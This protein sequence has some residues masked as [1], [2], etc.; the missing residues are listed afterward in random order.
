MKVTQE[1]VVD[2]QTTLRIELEEADLNPYL[3]Q[4][5]RRLAPQISLPGFRK[6][7][8]PRHIVEGFMGR[9]SLLNEVLDNMVYEVTSKAIE[10][11][12]IDAAGVPKIEDLDLDPVSFTAI[13]ALRPD[14]ELGDYKA[15]RV[16]YETDEV[17]DELVTERINNIRESL[18]SW[19]TV[20]R[21]PELGDLLNLDARG[22]IEGE[23]FWNREDGVLY[24]DEDGSVPV[25]GFPQAMVGI[26][27]GQETEFTLSI[28]E[29]FRDASIAGKEASF[30][31]T[32]NEVRERSLPELNDE[33]AQNLPDGYESLE[34]LRNAVK[35]G[36]AAD[37]EARLEQEYETDVIKALIDEATIT[38]PPVMLE[39]ETNRIRN[40]QEQMLERANIRVDDYLRS[41]G[42]TEEEV[43]QEA[44]EEAEQR[45]RR[46]FA[47]NKVSELENIEVTEQEIDERFNEMY[48]GQRMRRQERRSRREPLDDMLKYEKTV[49]LL[50]EI[51]KSEDH[52]EE[53]Q[54][55]PNQEISEDAQEGD[56]QDDE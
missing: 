37:A 44:E 14:V 9:E 38:I 55:E 34:A 3:D 1:E 46:T 13:V 7:K 30:S 41:I 26:E 49:A 24:L 16:P 23:E 19:E 15:I 11:Q 45:I 4:G 8:V 5:Y 43:Q 22:E 21:A 52:S 50:V 25:T 48:A 40:T 54:T 2:N 17:T 33:F 6:G 53:A 31:V 36:M 32:V 12:D 28:P 35:E 18:G 56:A 39:N 51:A 47:L 29:D 42:K 27:P 20:E 10:E